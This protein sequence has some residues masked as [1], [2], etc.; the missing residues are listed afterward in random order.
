MNIAHQLRE[1][2]DR[3]FDD[4]YAEVKW[5]ETMEAPN[6]K[7]EDMVKRIDDMPTNRPRVFKTHASPPILPF[8][9][10]VKYVVVM[11]NPEEA[12]V[13]MK[14]FT[15]NHSQEFL[16]YWGMPPEAFQ[17]ADLQAFYDAFVK[18]VGMDKM[19]FGFMAEWWKLRN[20]PNVLLLHYK[21]MVTDHEG[22]I[23]KISNFL[24]FGP[25]TD[26]EWS[27]ILEL[28]SFQWMKKHEHMFE[29]TSVWHIPVLQKGA[30]IRQGSSGLARIKDGM[31][32]EVA[33]DLENRGRD[34]LTDE[35]AFEWMY[36][37]GPLPD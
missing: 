33:S 16:K 11:R 22:S 5:I 10:N 13:S 19:L 34:I 21:D 24:N 37:G 12:V 23:T 25:Y 26:D 9:E 31:T 18:G 8:Q 27:T 36:S 3:S 32:E 4:I 35:A 15:S 20:K 7:V 14:A 17:W 2:G 29:A 30:M 1:K 6:S 28:T